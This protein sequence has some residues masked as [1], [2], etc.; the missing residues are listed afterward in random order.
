MLLKFGILSL[1][2]TLINWNVFK[3]TQWNH[4]VSYHD[5]LQLAAL[6]SLAAL[7]KYLNLCYFYKVVH[8]IFEF[9]NPP[10]TVR[11]LNYPNCNGRT[12]LYVQPCA[13]SNTL[14]YSFFPTTISS[15]NSLPLNVTFATTVHSF[16]TQLRIKCHS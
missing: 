15:W 13:N 11:I 9:P 6:P 12:D 4:N 8:N 2:S 7:R 10:C 3:L 16:K 1:Q 14:H 5:L